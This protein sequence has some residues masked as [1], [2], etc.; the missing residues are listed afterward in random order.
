MPWERL[1]KNSHKKK[2]IGRETE[3]PKE[4]A[5]EPVIVVSEGC[6]VVKEDRL[7]M[8]EG[9]S[10]WWRGWELDCRG[11]WW[12]PKQQ[13]EQWLTELG[14]RDLL[15]TVWVERP[16]HRLWCFGNHFLLEQRCRERE[17]VSSY[18]L[19]QPRDRGE[20]TW[21]PT[22]V[23]EWVLLTPWR[24]PVTPSCTPMAGITIYSSQGRGM[25]TSSQTL[26]AQPIT[27]D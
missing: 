23:K 21:P 3:K 8:A 6:R 9:V 4:K 22:S 20:T 12:E 2:K 14:Y 19:W 1:G 26:P 16:W 11:V 25:L 7:T 5:V 15:C 27:L 10:R 17:P 24:P 18:S 13:S